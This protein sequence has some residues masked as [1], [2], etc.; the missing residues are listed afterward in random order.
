[1]LNRYS[2]DLLMEEDL[3]IC[4][5]WIA[6]EELFADFDLDFAF[7]AL[8]ILLRLFALILIVLI[9][10]AFSFFVLQILFAFPLISPFSK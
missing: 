7:A 4:M 5:L 8:I 1:M 3:L 10:S 2:E 9:L 6:L